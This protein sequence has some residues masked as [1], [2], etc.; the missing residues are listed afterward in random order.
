[1]IDPLLRGKG[2]IVAVSGG[3]D[4]PHIGHL[5]LFEEAKKLGDWLVVILNGDGWVARKKGRSFMSAQDRKR[6]IEAFRPVDE[7]V[8]W[9]DGRDDV[10]QA[11]EHLRPRV[12]ANGGD[13]KEDNIPEV[14]TCNALGIE[15]AFNIGKSG[16]VRSSSELLRRYHELAPESKE[17]V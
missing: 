2:K 3:F 5:E 14:A 10:C 17:A 6:L 16:K 11:L 4:P 8:I 7:V 13:R 9:D 1:M 15:M 12:F